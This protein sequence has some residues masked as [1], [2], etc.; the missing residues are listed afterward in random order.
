MLSNDKARLK[1]TLAQKNGMPIKVE[2]DKSVSLTIV[3]LEF[4]GMASKMS[5]GL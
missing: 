2:S 1:K 4:V 3:G 5:S